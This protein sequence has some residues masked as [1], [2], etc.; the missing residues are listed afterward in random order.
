MTTSRSTASSA[1]HIYIEVADIDWDT[2]DEDHPNGNPDVI[3]PNAAGVL[4]A[5]DDPDFTDLYDDN[6]ELRDQ[7]DLLW[8]VNDRLTNR[9]DYCINGSVITQFLRLK[10]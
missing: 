1:P 7:G 4:I 6:G 3:L 5:T 9:Y 2:T 10:D 8:L